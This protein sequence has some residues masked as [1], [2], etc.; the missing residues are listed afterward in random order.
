MADILGHSWNRRILPLLSG[1]N[2]S[3]L[4]LHFGGVLVL[5]HGVSAIK[6]LSITAEQPIRAVP[7]FE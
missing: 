2:F 1:L 6:P 3:P 7:G 5:S 4:L